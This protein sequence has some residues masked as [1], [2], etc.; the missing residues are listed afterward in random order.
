M[1]DQ[2]LRQVEAKLDELIDLCTRL[3]QENSSLK[4]QAS[5]WQEERKRLVEKNE[6]ARTR[7]E[8]MIAHLKQ[9]EAES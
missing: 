1:S 3:E 2:M 4:A 5:N 9:L 7:V 6:L 8:A